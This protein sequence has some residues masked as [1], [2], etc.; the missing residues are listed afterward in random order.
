MSY[1]DQ[2]CISLRLDMARLPREKLWRAYACQEG[3]IR[4]A[5]EELVG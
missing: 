1:G 4:E 3:G 5:K 2:T